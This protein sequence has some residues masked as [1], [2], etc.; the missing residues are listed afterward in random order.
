MCNQPHYKLARRKFNDKPW[1]FIYA[2]VTIILFSLTVYNAEYVSIF[3]DIDIFGICIGC[4]TFIWCITYVIVYVYM[5]VMYFERMFD[6]TCI[7]VPITLLINPIVQFFLKGFVMYEI[8]DYACIIFVFYIFCYLYLRVYVSTMAGLT[9][10]IS[11]IILKH[12]CIIFSAFVVLFSIWFGLLFMWICRDIDNT[13]DFI[14]FTYALLTFLSFFLL[15]HTLIVFTMSVITVDYFFPNISYTIK[16]GNA[17]TNTMFSAGTICFGTFIEITSLWLRVIGMI[18]TSLS[19]RLQSHI[20]IW[21]RDFANYSNGWTFWHV[22]FA[23]NDYRTSMEDSWRVLRDIYCYILLSTDVYI[24]I[25]LFAASASLSIMYY[26]IITYLMS[27]QSEI[28]S[29]I[30][31]IIQL[32]TISGICFSFGISLVIYIIIKSIFYIYSVYPAG[33]KSRDRGLYDSI[34]SFKRFVQSI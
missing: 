11:K 17:L 31:S 18:T 13:S 7:Y 25:L 9:R 6:V 16:V 21:I 3:R 32:F 22:A 24:F 12:G 5:F 27:S 23:G 10:N 30:K 20:M 28:D 34:E 26:D 19:I 33:M 1:L 14:R 15:V 29:S 8:I 4:F 2:L